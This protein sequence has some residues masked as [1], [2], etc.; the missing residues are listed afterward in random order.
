MRIKRG[1]QFLSGRVLDS[2]SMGLQAGASPGAMRCFP[3]QDT[4]PLPSTSVTQKDPSLH[5]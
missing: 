1:A 2:R 3:E 5:D 4:Y